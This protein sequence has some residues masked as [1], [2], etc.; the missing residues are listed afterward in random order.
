[1]YLNTKDATSTRIHVKTYRIFLFHLLN[2]NKISWHDLKGHFSP[3]DFQ[4]IEMII[5]D[6]IKD[7]TTAAKK[8]L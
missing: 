1:M 4:K 5:Q 6:E 2:N 3:A 8:T 7:S